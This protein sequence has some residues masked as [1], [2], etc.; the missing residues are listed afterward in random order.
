MIKTPLVSRISNNKV[1][2]QRDLS[3]IPKD[4]IYFLVQK[5]NTPTIPFESME[6]GISSKRKGEKKMGKAGSQQILV[7]DGEKS[8]ATRSHGMRLMMTLPKE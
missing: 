1:D 7:K 2:A 4:H 5:N 6:K 8:T 3:T